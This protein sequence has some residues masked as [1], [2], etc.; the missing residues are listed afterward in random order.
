M[1]LNCSQMGLLFEWEY[2][3]I[4]VSLLHYLCAQQL[5]VCCFL[6]AN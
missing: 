3:S 1:Q 5:R 2:L 4:Y 6:E